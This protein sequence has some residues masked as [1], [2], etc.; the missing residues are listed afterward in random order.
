MRTILSKLTILTLLA[1]ASV[2]LPSSAPAAPASNVVELCKNAVGHN[3]QGDNEQTIGECTSYMLTLFSEGSPPHICKDL[4]ERG[5][6][7]DIGYASFSEC[8]REERN[9]IP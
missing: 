3:P 8:L 9:F 2:S 5:L 4:E 1:T 6:L 7:D